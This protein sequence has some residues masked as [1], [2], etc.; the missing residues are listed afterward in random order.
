VDIGSGAGL[1]GIVL[2]LA[3]PNLNITLIEPIPR[4][5]E[6]LRGVVDELA[7]GSVRILQIKAEKCREQFDIATARAVAPLPKLKE[8]AWPLLKPGGRLLAIKGESAAE[9]LAA[10]EL[11]GVAS[12]HLY[13][14]N[15]NDLPVARVIELVKAG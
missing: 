4:R 6:F 11:T 12:S 15:L 8:L 9:E 5:A 7:L 13:E 14:I 2:A 3:R 1:P 10:S